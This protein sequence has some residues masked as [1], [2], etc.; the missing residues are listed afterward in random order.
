MKPLTNKSGGLVD[1]K[2]KLIFEEYKDKEIWSARAFKKSIIEKYNIVP[3]DLYVKII[4][5]QIKKYGCALT[6]LR[7]S[8]REYDEH[9]K[10]NGVKNKRWHSQHA[11]EKQ[12]ERSYLE[13]L[14]RMNK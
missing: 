3:N 5:Y 9:Y 13:K 4:N 8:V 1:F 12:R 7:S 6:Q 11:L 14:E 2:E 10:F